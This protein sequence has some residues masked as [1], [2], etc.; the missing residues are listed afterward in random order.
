MR[1][2]ARSWSGKEKGSPARQRDSSLLVSAR[3]LQ[4][5]VWQ[6]AMRVPD[7]LTT[8]PGRAGEADGSTYADHGREHPQQGGPRVATLLRGGGELQVH[9]DTEDGI[10]CSQ[11]SEH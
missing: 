3:Q 6:Q 7:D 8:L 5:L 4:A 10:Q 9:D 11:K 1:A 2:G